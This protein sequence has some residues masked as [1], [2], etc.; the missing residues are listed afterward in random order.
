MP[1]P[2]PP[3][4]LMGGQGSASGGGWGG[5]QQ[6]ASRLGHRALGGRR[7]AW[8]RPE[9]AQTPQRT[10][11]SST[12]RCMSPLSDT[13]PTCTLAMRAHAFTRIPQPQQDTPCVLTWEASEQTPL[14]S[15]PGAPGKSRALQ[16]GG[17]GG[18]QRP[19]KPHQPAFWGDLQAAGQ[20]LP[21]LPRKVS[22]EVRGRRPVRF[23]LWA[24][25]QTQ[26]LKEPS[27]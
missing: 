12:Q 7:A 9:G 18:G 27:P 4:S 1:A 6:E 23:L 20:A 21:F 24:P 17:G 19:A 26:T 3:G 2:E 11:P 15:Q 10:M 14:P 25:S 8:D 5:S 13:R 16:R 22:E